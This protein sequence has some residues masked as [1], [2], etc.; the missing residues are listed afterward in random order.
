MTKRIDITG[1]RFG[2]WTAVTP[3]RP[4]PRSFWLCRCDCGTERE[5]ATSNLNKELTKSCGCWNLEQSTTHGHT[6]TPTHQTWSAMRS[7]CRT[8]HRYADRGITVDPRWDSFENFLADMGERPPGQ[9]L[10][11]I[12]NDGPYGPSNCRWATRAEQG[13][14]RENTVFITYRGRTQTVAQWAKEVGLSRG[15]LY[16]RIAIHG[17]P[18][19]RA[20]ETPVNP[21]GGVKGSSRPRRK[22]P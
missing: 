3:G 15:V 17:W 9:T 12:D 8:H 16:N 10:E 19:E 18:V 4:G 20:I 14:N 1:Q 7:R 13:N 2:R 22:T 11:R 6:G 5:V 21:V